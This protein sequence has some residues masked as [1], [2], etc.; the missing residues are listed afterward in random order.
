MGSVSITL[1]RCTCSSANKQTGYFT[2][3]LA[4]LH[5][6][7]ELHVATL[8]VLQKHCGLCSVEIE[9]VRQTQK[10]GGPA[11]PMEGMS[12]CSWDSH[13]KLMVIL[14]VH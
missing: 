2:Y 5:A 8:F 14:T 12:A 13:G 11:I 1:L 10:D 6:L 4:G 7:Q 3:T 9:H